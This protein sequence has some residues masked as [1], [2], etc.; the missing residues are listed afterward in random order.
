MVSE[1]NPM[2]RSNSTPTCSPDMANRWEVPVARKSSLTWG[3]SWPLSPNS[4]AW[5]NAD[6]GTGRFRSR[7]RA[8]ALLNVNIPL[9]AE[10]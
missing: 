2:A 10:S 1:T 4:R 7:F 3:G 8:K 5:A 6:W 9:L